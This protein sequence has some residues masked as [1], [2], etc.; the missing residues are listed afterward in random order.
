MLENDQTKPKMEENSQ[1]K[2]RIQRDYPNPVCHKLQWTVHIYFCLMVIRPWLN[3]LTGG[4]G[5]V[6]YMDNRG[7]VFSHENTPEG[8]TKTHKS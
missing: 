3:L 4:H 8:H 2:R 7:G 6:I 1:T 5:Q